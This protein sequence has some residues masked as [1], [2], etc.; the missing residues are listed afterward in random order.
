MVLHS[1]SAREE[2]LQRT[3]ED[4]SLHPWHLRCIPALTDNLLD[5]VFVFD[6]K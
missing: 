5:V 1:R 3:V 6:Y 2:D 4:I